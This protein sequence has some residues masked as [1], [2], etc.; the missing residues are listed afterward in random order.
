[1]YPPFNFWYPGTVFNIGP[2]STV[3]W[4]YENQ[5]NQDIYPQFYR[6]PLGLRG[7]LLGG[8]KLLLMGRKLTIASYPYWYQFLADIFGV[9]PLLEISTEPNFVGAN[10]MMGFPSVGIDY[11]KLAFWNE[12]MGKIERFPN[13]PTNQIIYTYN[14]SPLDTTMEGD[15]VGLRAVD[16][17]L[18][19]YY[20]SFPLYYLDSVSAKSLLTYVLNDFGEFPLGV[21]MIDEGIP[22]EFHLYDAYPNPF[23]PSTTIRFDL[24]VESD[25]KLIMYDIMGKEVDR[26]IEERKQ[27]GRYELTWNASNTASGV[28]FYRMYAQ[29]VMQ[30]YSTTVTKKILLMK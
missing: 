19:A 8:G 28:Y 20:M 5:T 9:N 12:T 16:S 2:Y 13:A 26:L 10:G 7:Y 11:Q 22:R 27:P 6:M 30:S 24:P 14:S 3:I 15:P 29:G 1:M 17:N 21:R 18:K 25:V 4:L 23:N